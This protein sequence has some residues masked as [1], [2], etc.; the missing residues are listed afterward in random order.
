MSHEVEPDAGA[1]ATDPTHNPSVPPGVGGPPGWLLRVI[2]DQRA[3]FLVVGAA[4]TLIGLF[5]FVTFQ[6]LVGRHVGYMVTLACAHVASVLCAFWL[7]RLVVFRVRGHV[8]RDLLRFESVYLSALGV[9]AVLLPLLVEIAHLPVLVSQFLIVGVTSLM[10]WFGHKHFSFR[11]PAAA[12]QPS[13]SSD[14]PHDPR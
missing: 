6:Y 7:Y 10:S 14:S 8:L 2:H 1:P 3:A 9:N 5:W 4:N 12:D 11:R 13:D